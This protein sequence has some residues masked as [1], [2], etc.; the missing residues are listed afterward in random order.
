MN[1]RTMFAALLLA[2][3]APLS[4][5]N[6]VRAEPVSCPDW[7]DRDRESWCEEREYVVP[8]S[9]ALEVDAGMNGGISVTG[10][11]RDEI[12]IV[13]RVRAHADEESEARAIAGEI[14]ID[15]E[16]LVEARG[17]RLRDREAWWSVSYEIHAPRGT[18]L[19]LTAMNGGIRLAA[20]S[21]SV[22]AETTN[23]G[24][25]VTGGAG[26]IRGQTTNGGIDLELTGRRWEGSGVDLRSTN[27]GVTIRVPEGYSA[28]LE[29]GTVNGGI[30]LDFPITV[31]GQL[32]RTL[33][34]RLGEGGPLI[35][36]MTTNGGV[37]LERS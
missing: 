16:G 15:V 9:A 33:R 26:R 6:P 37:T 11:D 18:Q 3:A 29:T 19:R 24:I 23:G 20:L 34:T 28:D 14:E 21:G 7:G 8:A 17:P 5:Q 32:R 13:A 25:S 2:A 10:W 35:R 36:A 31:E 4:A 27:G 12:R 1:R 22:D 30:E